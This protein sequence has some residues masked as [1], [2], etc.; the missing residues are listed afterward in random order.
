MYLSSAIGFALLIYALCPGMKGML[1]SMTLMQLRKFIKIIVVAYIFIMPIDLRAAK[2][3]IIKSFD[4]RFSFIAFIN[5]GMDFGNLPSIF[6]DT[7]NSRYLDFGYL[8]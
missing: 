2:I 7:V 5:K 8:E 1:F 3:S 4:S 6:R